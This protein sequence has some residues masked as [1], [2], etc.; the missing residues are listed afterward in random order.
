MLI[1]TASLI[2]LGTGVLMDRRYDPS[3]TKYY[4]W[5]VLYPII[6]WVQMSLITVIA[7]P[8]GWFK[9]H[10]PGTWRSPRVPD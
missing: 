5:A 3:I 1:A 2:Q 6:Y 8:S 4:P 10:G 9:P 7:T